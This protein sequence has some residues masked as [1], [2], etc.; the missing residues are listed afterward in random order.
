MSDRREKQLEIVLKLN[1]LTRQGKIVWVSPSPFGSGLRYAAKFGNRDYLLRDSSSTSLEP[2]TIRSAL[3]HGSEDF[4][5]QRSHFS[6]LIQD[7]EKEVWIPPMPAVDD[8]V[9]TVHHQIK[10]RETQVLDRVLKDLEEAENL[11]EE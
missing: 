11:L 6:L 2:V 7:E 4:L 9:S 5:N 8:L 1:K 3:K 10:T